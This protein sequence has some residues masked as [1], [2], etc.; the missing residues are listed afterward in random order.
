MYNIEGNKRILRKENECMKE[1]V[2]DEVDIQNIKS[3]NE[4]NQ[5]KNE[6]EVLKKKF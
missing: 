3:D 1:I 5:L 6:L 4:V 2:K